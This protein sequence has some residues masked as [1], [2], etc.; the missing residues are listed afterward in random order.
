MAIS[1]MLSSDFMLLPVRSA[2]KL[3]GT[4]PLI[5]AL[6]I[7]RYPTH[8]VG[9]AGGGDRA[10]GDTNG[11]YPLPVHATNVPQTYLPL[12]QYLVHFFRSLKDS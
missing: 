2:G 1:E 12:I 7:L 8:S 6:S 5:S 9:K 3:L 4:L 11:A 10:E